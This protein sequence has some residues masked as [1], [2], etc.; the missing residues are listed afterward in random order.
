MAKKIM[1]RPKLKSRRHHL[2]CM[3]GAE[4]RKFMRLRDKLYTLKTEAAKERVRKQLRKL[5]RNRLCF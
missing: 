1:H 2:K 4:M 5:K 3:S